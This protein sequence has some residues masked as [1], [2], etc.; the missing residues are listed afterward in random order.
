MSEERKPEESIVD[1]EELFREYFAALLRNHQ[2]GIGNDAAMAEIAVAEH[3]K[4][5]PKKV[6]VD[7]KV[8]F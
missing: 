8:P 3:R 2:G 1:D 7:P 4:L 6:K 5:F